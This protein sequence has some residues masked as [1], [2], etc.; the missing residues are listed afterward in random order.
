MAKPNL[1]SVR[2]KEDP[3]ITR[4]T[5]DFADSPEYIAYIINQANYGN[6][7]ELYKYARIIVLIESISKL[8]NLFC[9]IIIL[10]F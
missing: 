7:Y 4:S 6:T 5:I 8:P 9:L 10:L 3:M 2:K 1:T